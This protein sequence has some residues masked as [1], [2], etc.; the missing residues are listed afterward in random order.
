MQL[1]SESI[2]RNYCSYINIPYLVR[3]YTQLATFSFDW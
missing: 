2:N 3:R 1:P